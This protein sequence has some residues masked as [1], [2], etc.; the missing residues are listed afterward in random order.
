MC[1]HHKACWA[2]TEQH[3]W[4][5]FYSEVKATLNHHSHYEA[6]MCYFLVLISSVLFYRAGN[7]MKEQVCPNTWYSRCSET[8]HC[9]HTR[10]VYTHSSQPPVLVLIS[11]GVG[12][13]SH[14][15]V[16]HAGDVA[17]DASHLGGGID[18][19]LLSL[20]LQ[21]YCLKQRKQTKSGAD[22]L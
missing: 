9:N 7:S 1:S 2:L 8:L 22:W 17:A 6:Q 4:S 3:C 14:Q 12:P 21:L 13:W 10:S 11:S 5:H 19:T 18:W 16:V 20:R 15:P